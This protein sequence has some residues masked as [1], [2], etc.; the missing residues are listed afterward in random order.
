MGKSLRVDGHTVDLEKKV[1]GNGAG[2]QTSEVVQTSE[3]YVTYRLL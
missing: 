1:L 3:V 2:S